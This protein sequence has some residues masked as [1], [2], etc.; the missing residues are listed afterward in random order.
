MR[1]TRSPEPKAPAGQQVLAWAIGAAAL[2]QKK[3]RKKKAADGHVGLGF[4][5]CIGGFVDFFGGPSGLS[6]AHLM[7]CG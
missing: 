2:P 3:A 4:R 6:I 7:S 1:E 5:K